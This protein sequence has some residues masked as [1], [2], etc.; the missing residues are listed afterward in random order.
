MKENLRDW[1]VEAAEGED[2]E[3]VVFGKMGG[4]GDYGKKNVPGYDERPRG[5]VIEWAT[6]E[7][8]LRYEFDSGSGAPGCEAVYA[9]TASRIIF[10]V[11]YDGSTCPCWVP[12]NPCECKPEMPGG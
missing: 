2:V 1:I 4:R 11:R 8:L 5:K 10:I 3:A 7:P 9:W 12:R 6:A